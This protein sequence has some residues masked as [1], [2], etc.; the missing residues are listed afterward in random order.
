M[1]LQTSP[2]NS[3][4]RIESGFTLV[5]LLVVIGI[6]ALLISILLPALSKARENANQ[7][8]CSANQRQ[9]LMGMTLHANDHK[10]YMP[11]AGYLWTASGGTAPAD[12]LDPNRIKYEYVA[13][14]PVV[15]AT[16]AGVGKYLGQDLDFSSVAALQTGMLTVHSGEVDTTLLD[17]NRHRKRIVIGFADGH[18]ENLPLDVGVLTNVSLSMDFGQVK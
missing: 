7:V 10:G 3:K 4:R 17:K 1:K 9:I 13:N 15:S 16:A 5:E 12:V 18:V 8:K 14:P 11:M 2:P 6:I